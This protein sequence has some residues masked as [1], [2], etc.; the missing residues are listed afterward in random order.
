MAQLKPNSIV[1]LGVFEWMLQA[2]KASGEGRLLAFLHDA[3]YQLKKK[4][5]GEKLN[6]NSC[7]TRIF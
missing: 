4:K 5:T 2:A 1:K 6:F 3:R 7:R